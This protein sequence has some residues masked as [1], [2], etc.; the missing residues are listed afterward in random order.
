MKSQNKE[1]LN[2]IR[3]PVLMGNL[4]SFFNGTQFDGRKIYVVN[5]KTG[6]RFFF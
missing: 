6:E 2:E 5:L 1:S 4:D 3:A